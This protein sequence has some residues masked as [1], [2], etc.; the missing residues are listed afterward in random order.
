MGATFY[1]N[2]FELKEMINPKGHSDLL[3]EQYLSSQGMYNF[4]YEKDWEGIS[5]H[6]D[7]SVFHDDST[8]IF[9][10]KER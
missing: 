8:Y 3:F 1:E 6:P 4:E 10:V 7:Y 2:S 5:V 9:E